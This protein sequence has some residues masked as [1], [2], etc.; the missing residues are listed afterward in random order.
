MSHALKPM[1]QEAVQDVVTSSIRAARDYITS[2]VAP[3][4]HEAARYFDGKCDIEP[5][6]GRSDAVVTVCRDVVRAVKPAIAKV[7][8]QHEQAVSYVA[9]E[10]SDP[11]VADRMTRYVI[12]LL[13]KG[14]GYR[15]RMAAI[16]DT[17]VAKTGIVKACWDDTREVIVRHFSQISEDALANIARD[18]D[19]VS[20]QTTDR[21]VQVAEVMS[22][23]GQTIA[24]RVETY[25]GVVVM[26]GREKG[27]SIEAIP[28]ECFFIDSDATS[29]KSAKVCGHYKEGTLGD[30]L[31]MGY[32]W[33]DVKDLGVEARDTE[34]VERQ[35]YEMADID[36]GEAM[37][38][39]TIAEAYIRMDMLGT[40]IP[41]L[42]R[43]I[44][45]G[46][47]HTV[48]SVEIVQDVPYADYHADPTGHKFFSKSLVEMVIDDQ[49]RQS[50]MERAYQD[51]VHYA[52]NPRIAALED[53]VNTDDLNHASD[54]GAVLREKVAGAI[55]FLGV[56]DMT[57]SLLQGLQH[58]R[59]GID[60]K[61][62]VSS[63]SNALASDV[64]TGTTV[65]GVNAAVAAAS[66]QAELYVR[67]IAEGDRRL[68]RLLADIIE[69]HPEVLDD[70]DFDVSVNVGLGQGQD[71]LKLAA[72][73]GQLDF[74]IQV[75]TQ[76]GPDNGIVTMTHIHNL[77]R[78]IMSLMGVRNT[79][80][81]MSEV[82]PEIEEQLLARAAQQAQ[83]AQAN[84]Q[85]DP[86]VQ[87]EMVKAEAAAQREDR[88]L[89]L[90][91]DKAVAKIQ[92]D[93]EKMELEAHKTRA[94]IEAAQ[95]E[96]EDDIS[97]DRAKLSLA[98][99][100]M[101]ADL[102]LEIGTLMQARGY[103]MDGTSIRRRPVN[104]Q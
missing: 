82:T 18:E 71:D 97:I 25:S 20:V 51:N 84:A 34:S 23:D 56:P 57:G 15:I 55:R 91:E 99:E 8:L 83:E 49:D 65:A 62:G 3:D 28:P 1:S 66:A 26:R 50:V 11:R 59:E 47:D 61:T 76:Y 68:F 58:G 6:E 7:F 80:R 10:G 78:D 39:V 60:A 44:A 33:E 67:N 54:F 74:A 2:E 22:P 85:Q 75:W 19:V 93:R 102:M 27:I 87:A 70:D 40:G 37:R 73:Q 30:L 16:D 21:Q 88:K 64:L 89:E 43:V 81:Y 53:Q 12:R 13:S 72:L 31:Q 95:R 46:T 69:A 104:L 45:G 94:E 29:L 36:A 24:Q 79:S 90:D 9:R 35:P 17:L 42:H 101:D 4:R 41:L 48:L 14:D 77:R 103:Y 5:E 63:A 32:S 96:H 92:I 86:L 52:N 98:R 100:E 38:P